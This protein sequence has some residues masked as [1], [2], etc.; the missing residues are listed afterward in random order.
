MSNKKSSN[1]NIIVIGELC[2][3][4]FNYCVV[5][6]LSPE[7]PVPVLQVVN[8]VSNSGMAG[9]V[10]ANLK[11]I[12]K[13]RKINVN[14]LYPKGV[15]P[16]KIRYVDYKTNH[17]FFRL[18]KN[19]SCNR[20]SFTKETIS[21]IQQADAI[22]ISDYDKGYLM[23]DDISSIRK[24]NKSAKIFLDTKKIITKIIYNSV[25]YIKINKGE[26]N[27]NLY[28]NPNLLKEYKNKIIITLGEDGAFHKGV[29][30]KKNAPL[31]TIDVSGAGDTFMAALVSSYI[32]SNNISDS[33]NYANELARKV[34]QERGVSVA[35][36]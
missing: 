28:N 26:F 12:T 1:K 36:I 25:D 6:R 13:N 19:D 30:Y 16:Q 14:S 24:M 11:S 2:K 20:I 32:L 21:D 8:S 4:I 18:D 22:L 5:D 27:R 34:V 35:K 31:H 33:I 3:D 17:Y 29:A 9:N 23:E 7:A 10:F 15:V